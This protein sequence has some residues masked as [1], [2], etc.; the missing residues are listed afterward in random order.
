MLYEQQH[1]S[2]ILF[3]NTDRIQGDTQ[4]LTHVSVVLMLYARGSNSQGIDSVRD[5]VKCKV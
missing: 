3:I 1:F 4:R 5:C 2:S